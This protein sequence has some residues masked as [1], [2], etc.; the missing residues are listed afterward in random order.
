ME[1]FEAF[2]ENGKKIIFELVE[3]FGMNDSE[4]AVLNSNNDVNTYIL[5]IIYDKDG[6]I[7]LEGIDDDEL[8]DAI[9]IYEELKSEKEK[10]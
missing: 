7:N 6:N 10:I 1:R 8:S 4:Y 3:T 9:E 5:K 2:D